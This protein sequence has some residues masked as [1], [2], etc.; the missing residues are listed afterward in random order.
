[1]DEKLPSGLT[2]AYAL[3]N[4]IRLSSLAYGIV[5]VHSRV[6]YVTNKV[7]TTKHDCVLDRYTCDLDM[8]KHLANCKLCTK[9]C[10]V[11][12]YKKFLS[13]Y[14]TVLRNLTDVLGTS[15]SL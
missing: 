7:L 15:M 2:F 3:L 12:P 6:T 8:N 11:H 13:T 5:S 10:S 1:M 14:C 4:K 9:Y